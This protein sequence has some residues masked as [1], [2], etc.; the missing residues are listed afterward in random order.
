MALISREQKFLKEIFDRSISAVALILLFPFLALIA[1]L[2]LIYSGYPVIYRQERV[3]KYS[4]IFT[5]FK[6]RTMTLNSSSN[7][8]S[9]KGDTRITPIGYWLRKYKL[10]ELPELWNILKGDMSIVGPRPDVIGYADKFE[11]D[12]YNIL[13]IK[14]GITGPASLKYIDEEELLAKYEDPK[15]YND[16]I[17]FPDKVRI[18]SLYI[19]NWSFVLDLKVIWNTIIRKIYVEEDY[20]IKGL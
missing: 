17:I 19:S 15:K 9:V 6:F 12:N 3:G 1:L 10:D 2:I 20:F 14:P 5:I 13:L 4:R 7:T 16:E 18:N 11:R 8:I